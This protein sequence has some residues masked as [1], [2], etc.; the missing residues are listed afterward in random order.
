MTGEAK[1]KAKAKP[2]PAIGPAD[3][4]ARKRSAPQ[5]ET[6]AEVRTDKEALSKLSG[7]GGARARKRARAPLPKASEALQ[8]RTRAL[9]ID[10]NEGRTMM[11]QGK[12]A[13][14]YC[15]MCNVQCKDSARWLDHING[16]HHLRQ[17]GQT[18][19]VRRVTLGDVRA[20]LASLREQL[21]PPDVP[22]ASAKLLAKSQRYDFDKR[23][24]AIADQYADEKRRRREIRKQTKSEA[25]QAAQQVS[26]ETHDEDAMAML[27][28]GAFG[29]TK[30]R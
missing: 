19:Q 14:W 18:T 30:K 11:V 5:P 27:G 26:Q 2:E 7:G 16:R 1:A 8:Q 15:A 4:L 6:A 29:S 28:F 3:P 13:G 20:K 24:K 25:R 22:G 12:G 10:V 17:L 21:V 9:N 23:I